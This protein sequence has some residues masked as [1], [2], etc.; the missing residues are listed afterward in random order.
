MAAQKINIIIAGRSYPVKA[1]EN[2]IDAIH[3]IEKDINRKI[4]E[5][6]GLYKTE[7]KTDIITLILL[8]CSLENFNL[9]QNKGKDKDVLKLISDIESSINK[10]L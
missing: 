7:N 2:E 3:E 5:Y 8:N 4:N 1:E 6:T 9:K 10:V